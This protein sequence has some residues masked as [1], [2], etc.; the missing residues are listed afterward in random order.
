[1]VDP[2]RPRSAVRASSASSV[3]GDEASS[4][5]ADSSRAALPR[6]G[7][8]QRAAVG[9][10]GLAAAGWIAGR[11]EVQAAPLLHRVA[12]PQFKFSLAAYSYRNL[13]QGKEA[14]LTL[15]DFL[16]DCAKMG[17]EG[18]E[19][20]SYYFPAQVTD[21]YLHQL[22]REAFLRGLDVSGTA[23]GND[24]CHPPGEK[25]TE[26]IALVKTWIERA[27]KLT[28]PV[29]RIFAG[30]S[31]PGQPLP[32]AQK[33]AIEA[34]E[35][36]C[37]YAGKFGVMLALENHGGITL[38][39]DEMLQVVHAVKSPW[40]GVNLDSGNFHSDDVYG[41][42]EKIAPFA[43][44]AQIKVVMKPANGK[45]E[46]A[47]FPR[48][49]KILKDAGYRGYVVLEYEETDEDPRTACPAFMDK[50]RAAF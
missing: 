12:R 37:D 42:L 35:E 22:R 33:L 41:D 46:P 34:I 6:R 47:D 25:R 21:E 7:F 44:N 30:P 4:S 17:L 29:I 48:L 11:P 2:L 20:T 39:V 45:K 43:V 16:D 9:G 40:F 24:F 26:Q 1:M 28:A 3:I 15:I 5:A 13:L 8:L 31:K 36:C 49:A 50:L 23:V 32:E 14:K 10:L 38:K 27:A 19:L 18:V